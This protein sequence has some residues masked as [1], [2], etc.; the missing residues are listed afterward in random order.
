MAQVQSLAQEIPL[1][2]G[3]AGKKKKNVFKLTDVKFPMV[4]SG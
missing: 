4:F 3:T 1:V 2:P